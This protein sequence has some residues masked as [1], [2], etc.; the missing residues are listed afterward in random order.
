MLGHLASDRYGIRRP[1]QLLPQGIDVGLVLSA[2]MKIRMLAG[3][4]GPRGLEIPASTL[5]VFA[6]SLLMESA[7][8]A[9]VAMFRL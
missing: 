9:V 3:V 1:V 7:P 4:P 6:A 2:L 8:P 5:T